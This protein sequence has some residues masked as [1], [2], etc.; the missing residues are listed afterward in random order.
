MRASAYPQTTL[1]IVSQNIRPLT[2][3]YLGYET[4]VPEI[5]GQNRDITAGQATSSVQQ[6]SISAQGDGQIRVFRYGRSVSLIHRNRLRV[7]LL[8]QRDRFLFKRINEDNG[9]VN[10]ISH[11]L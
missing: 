1:Q 8:E 3:G 9:S 7:H 2:A 6:G 5:Y 10:S 4:E 11:L